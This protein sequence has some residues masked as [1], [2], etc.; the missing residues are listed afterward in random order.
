MNI[1]LLDFSG[2]DSWKVD[3]IFLLFLNDGT[4]AFHLY[5]PYI[6]FVYICGKMIY[7]L[8]I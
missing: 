3:S 2:Y 6:F 5:L 7:F 4:I 1:M 8:L